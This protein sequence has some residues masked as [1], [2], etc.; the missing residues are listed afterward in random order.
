MKKAWFAIRSAILWIFSGLHFF[1]VVPVLIFLGVFLDAR[2]HD[3]LQRGLCRRIAFLSGARVEAIRSAGFDASRTCFFFVNHVNF[4]DPF[5]LYCA[6]PQFVR[7]W[8]LESHFKIPAYGWLMKRFGNVP[9][10]DVRRPS[11]LKHH[12]T[13]HWMLWRAKI[14]V[15]LHDTIETKGLTKEDVP[16][17][18][19]RVREIVAAPVEEALRRGKQGI[20]GHAEAF[21]EGD[22]S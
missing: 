5:M 8:E 6:I 12:R 7:G 21:Q 14:T 13:G 18:R 17:L 22:D 20:R 10:P 16:A 1:L 19:E 2:K 4:F 9:V 11:D 3:W 15:H